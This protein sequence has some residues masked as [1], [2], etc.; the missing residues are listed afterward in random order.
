MARTLD[1]D[2]LVVGAGASGMAFTDALVGNDPTAQVVVVDRRDAPGG[3]WRDSYPFVRLHQASVFYGVA[4]R[5]L[6]D[7]SK[8]ASG[9]EQGLHERATAPQICAYYDDVRARLE[10]TGRVTFLLGCDHLGGGEVRARTGE[11]YAVRVRRAVVDATYL[12]PD[13]PATTLPSFAVGDRARMVPV[14]ELPAVEDAPSQHVVVGSGKT[15]TDAIVWLLGRGTDPG[16]ICWVRPRDPWML[17]RAVVQPD[18]AVILGMGAAT[19]EA[20]AAAASLDDLFLRLEDAGVMLRIDQAVLPTMARC[21]T[22]GR[23]ELDLLRTV[24]HV[25]RLG[26]VRRVDAGSIELERGSVGVAP[27]ALV[28]HCSARGLPTPPLVPIW[29]PGT[30]TLQ[31]IRAGFPC[32]GAALA[33]YVE[34]T[35]PDDPDA[36]NRVCPSSP[37][38]N[39]LAEWVRMQVL[40]S[41]AA[42]AFRV[43][44]DVAAWANECLLNP[45]RVPAAR[46]DDPAV[47]AMKERIGAASGPGLARMAELAGLAG[48]AGL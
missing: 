41:R 34:A 48:L 14:G 45:A 16:A 9:P 31:P 44:P 26:H 22:L 18:P 47:G 35:R 40:G 17:D 32:F 2:Y 1:A 27:D 19:M 33:G 25:V 37:Y 15:A 4:S 8:Q 36:K 13:I 12:Q 23:W 10:D 21:P 30:V 3:H 46:A 24:E 11:S 5:E 29:G 42:A 38:G 20:G 43:V 28:V 7:G 39:S 6:G